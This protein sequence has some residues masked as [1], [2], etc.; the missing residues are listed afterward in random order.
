MEEIVIVDTSILLNVLDVPGRN[1]NRKSVFRDFEACISRKATF[2]VPLGVV[3]ETGNHIARISDGNKRRKH[4]EAFRDEMVNAV[5]ANALAGDS[6]WSL[7]LL[8]D[9]EQLLTWLNGFPDEATRGIGLVDL[10]IIREWEA[11]C[12]RHSLSRVRIWSLDKN[13]LA[14]YDRKPG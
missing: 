2:L 5:N 4:A 12:K 8:R 13:H 11:A 10:S 14:G 9:S 6:P 1:Q 3:L 7:I